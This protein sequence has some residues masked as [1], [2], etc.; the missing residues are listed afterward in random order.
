MRVVAG[1][2]L[3]AMAALY[4]LALQHQQQD[5]A[6]GYARAF[7]EAALVGGLA[8][9]FAVTALFRRPL[10]LPIPH[11]AIIPNS[12][13]RIADTLGDFVAVNFLA[14]Q[15]IGTHLKEQD[16]ASAL[17]R[18]LA[19]P[20]TAQRIS[21]GLMDALPAIADLLDDEVVSDFIRRQIGDLSRDERL[22]MLI[23]RGLNALTEGGR[24]QMLLDAAL[25][26]G[27]RALEQNEAAIRAQ[28]RSQT[29]WVWRLISLDARASDA[30]IGAIETT[31][32]EISRDPDHPARQR[33]TELIQ[34]FAA[35]LERSPDLRR[36]VERFVADVL[37]HPS[38]GIYL[39]DMWRS[40]KEAAQ[41]MAASPESDARA[42]LS[43]AIVRVGQALLDDAQVQ[44]TLNRR[45]RALL[46]EIADRHGRDVGAL[47]SQTIRN[48]D[49]KTVVDKLEQSVGADLQY[50]R[51]NGTVIG[52][53][54][55]LAL[56]QTAL[57]LSN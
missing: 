28:V 42:A 40:L 51:I 30:L 57:M 15:V 41:A 16:L 1:G 32:Q 26:E 17:G 24:H 43:D 3:A 18:Q 13:D 21:G 39:R 55:G 20:A 2:L 6:W 27:W 35:D 44:E 22:P 34:T 31:L 5:A 14:P 25:S 19:D 45:L 36:Q 10:G 7:A 9:W 56:H 11:T 23:G 47:I 50:I 33:V 49:T 37:A 12:K 52:G 4:I 48:W 29:S 53:L 46:I 8:D 54:I 38:V